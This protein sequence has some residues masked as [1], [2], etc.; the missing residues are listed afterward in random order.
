MTVRA[1]KQR[2][3]FQPP[4]RQRPVVDPRVTPTEQERRMSKRQAVLERL[5]QGPATNIELTAVGGLRYNA[6][7][8]EL[9]KAGYKFRKED[10]GG[11]LVRWT[12]LA[13]PPDCGESDEATETHHAEAQ[14][15]VGT[16]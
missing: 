8:F 9:E 10:L 5:R 16:V 1:K 15:I 4:P 2:F 6:R 14:S 11:G 7:R 3:L 13:E 12:L